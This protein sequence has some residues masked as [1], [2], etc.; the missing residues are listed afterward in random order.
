M[1]E[2]RQQRSRS[3]QQQS[4]LQYRLL[5]DEATSMRYA[6][7]EKSI[8]QIRQCHIKAQLTTKHFII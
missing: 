6:K 8:R 2:T 5:A 7:M 1:K 3:R 4:M